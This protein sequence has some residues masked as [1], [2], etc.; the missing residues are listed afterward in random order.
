MVASRKFNSTDPTFSLVN[1]STDALDSTD[2]LDD[3][4]ML[5]SSNVASS[6]SNGMVVE[7]IA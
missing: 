7:S 6:I 3:A 2:M 4:S 1:P 5:A